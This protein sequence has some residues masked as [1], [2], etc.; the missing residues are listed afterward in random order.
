MADARQDKY[1]LASQEDRSAP[2][3]RLSIPAALRPSGS[4][5]FQ[6]AVRDLSLSGF[7]ATAINR[8]HPGTLCW[9]TLPGL[10]SMQARVVWWDNGL[11][12]CA[13]ENLLSPIVHDNLLARWLGDGVYNAEG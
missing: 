2:R 5:G 7:S 4:K 1:A 6:T 9:L 8:L 12:G 10:H 11:V 3:T 13:F